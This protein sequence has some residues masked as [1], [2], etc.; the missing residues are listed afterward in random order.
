MQLYKGMVSM[1]GEGHPNSQVG[2]ADILAA[3][4]IILTVLFPLFVIPLEYNWLYV[5]VLWEFRTQPFFGDIILFKISNPINT[6]SF[7]LPEVYMAIE[8]Y[9]S[10]RCKSQ[11]RRR[12]IGKILIAS[13]VFLAFCLISSIW[14]STG[15][16]LIPFPFA[17]IISAIY[18][19]CCFPRPLAKP[20]TQK[21]EGGLG[22]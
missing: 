19:I 7:W 15:F 20:W 11:T 14:S 16:V 1:D 8:M 2:V 13:S 5:S 9:R 10:P 17:T 4:V 6:V 18:A 21:E 12:F 3:I 22:R